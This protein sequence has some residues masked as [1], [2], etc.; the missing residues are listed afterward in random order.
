MLPR[1][2]EYCGHCVFL[3]SFRSGGLD[4]DGGGSVK[5]ERSEPRQRAW[6]FHE[7]A[8]TCHGFVCFF[9]CFASGEGLWQ[10][11]FSQERPLYWRRSELLT[12]SPLPRFAGTAKQRKPIFLHSHAAPPSFHPHSEWTL[13]VRC[14]LRFFMER[15]HLDVGL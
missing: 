1:T 8:A 15:C 14:I 6:P 11:R 13:I 12:G 10:R 3:L 7:K 5:G 2:W 9:L 4:G